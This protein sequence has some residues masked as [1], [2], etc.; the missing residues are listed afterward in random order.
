MSREERKR[1]EVF[2]RVKRCEL[3]LAK[4]AELVGLSY[5]Q[6]KRV[7]ARYRDE[8]DGGLVHRLRGRASNRGG[9]P[10]LRERVLALY[11]ARYADFGPT[12]AVEYLAAEQRIVLGV[13]TLR[14]WLI[15]AGLW[16]VKRKR[17]KHR[18][19]RPRKEQAGELIQM[20]GSEHD[21]FE[22]RRPKASL[23]VMIDDATNWTY[24]RFFESE[25][26]V[27]AMTTFWEY[28]KL[29]GLPQALYVDH[30]SIYETT[31]DATTDE[32]LRETGALTQFGR[33]MQE[34]GV[35]LSLAHSP[36][37][38]GRVERRH[39]VFQD[40]LIKALR[41][42]GI[43]DLAGA[44]RFLEQHFLP[45]LQRRFVVAA[46]SK[47]DLHR[48]VPRGVR[49]E[50]VLAY[51][52]TRVVQ[53]DW[54]VQWR[55]RWL[56]IGERERSAGLARRRVLVVEQLDGRIELVHGG[57]SLSWQELP[58]RPRRAPERQTGPTGLD[59][60]GSKPAANHPWRAPAVIASPGPCLPGS[61]STPVPP[62]VRLA[63]RG[64]AKKRKKELI[65]N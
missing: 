5:R 11:R 61:A 43:N 54:T 3:T 51:H 32:E 58:E 6:A 1:L 18:R 31:R 49:L 17:G 22:A 64:R 24:A 39:A 59:R 21:W 46:Q 36:Q 29:R 55:G 62:A 33:A 25:T 10:V 14:E 9:D 45:D 57:R 20:D 30:D 4:A 28:V 15:A 8:G 34:L 53:N 27:A 56:Q 35:K 52:E 47:A 23:M 40:R 48:R 42:R 38:K 2:S 26:T 19:W 44:N 13:E 50:R 7:Y 63:S 60:V 37:A 12:L 65:P 41:L 16:Q